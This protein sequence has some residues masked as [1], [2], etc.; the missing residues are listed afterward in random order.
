MKIG[1]LKLSNN[2]IMAPLAGITDLAFRTIV[3]GYG[4]GLCYTEMLSADGLV[5]GHRGTLNYLRSDP[6]DRPLIVQ[7]FGSDPDVLAAAARMIEEMHLADAVD[8]NMGCPVKPVVRRGAG[9][10]LMRE[11][12]K[13]RRI[14]QAARK[15]TTLPL[16][17]KIRAGWSPKERN[18]LEIARIAEDEGADAVAVHPRTASQG[19]SGRSDWSVIAEIKTAV[20][21]PVIGNGDV[22]MP[23]DVSAMID[24]TGCDAVM[25]GRSALGNPWIFRNALLLR[26]GKGTEFAAHE[27]KARLIAEHLAMSVGLYG[28]VS[29]VKTFRKH[30]FWYTRGLR[31]SAAFRKGA[32]TITGKNNVLAAV[33]AY[34]EELARGTVEE[35]KALDFFENMN[36]SCNQSEAF[37]R[38]GPGGTEER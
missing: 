23:D 37:P 33:S 24:S 32:G 7:V 11:P 21:I 17:V 38:L 15:A 4:C 8:I 22:E 5:R 16:T 3:R 31:G 28:E 19:F 9:A 36:I 20:N 25:I 10:A 14:L 1:N 6:G 30:L 12:E 26:A 18:A 2:L 35:K 34:F 29:G 13:V 27:E